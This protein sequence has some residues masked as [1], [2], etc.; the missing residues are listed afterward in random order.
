MVGVVLADP[1][2]PPDAAFVPPPSSPSIN[3]VFTDEKKSKVGMCRETKPLWTPD[4]IKLRVSLNVCL[5]WTTMHFRMKLLTLKGLIS[6]VSS[7]TVTPQR[8]AE[9][10]KSKK[11]ED[12]QEANRFIKTMVKEVTSSKPVTC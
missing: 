4:V 3:P 2:I 7:Q 11:P 10:L 9:L 12:L 1:E 6:G 8:L 5:V